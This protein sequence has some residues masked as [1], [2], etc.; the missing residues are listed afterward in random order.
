MTLSKRLKMTAFIVSA[1]LGGLSVTPASAL[2]QSGV[3]Q[4]NV[5]AGFGLVITSSRALSCVFKPWRGKTE[6]Y[7]G[8][9]SRFGLDLG[10]TTEGTIVWDVV[11]ATPQ[12]LPRYALAGEYSG[13][14]ANITIGAGLG[15]NA[16][17]GGGNGLSLQ[18]LSLTAQTGLNLAAGIGALNL[19]PA[20]RPR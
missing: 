1:A 6:Y 20:P 16:L 11:S 5:A 13:A 10:A 18:P 4:C 15:A 9:I 7:T 8:T 19:Q 17:V 2:I 14:T 12:R 3:L